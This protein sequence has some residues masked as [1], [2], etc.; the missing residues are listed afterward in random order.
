M[1]AVIFQT[2]GTPGGTMPASP[3]RT[4]GRVGRNL[5]ALSGE[6]LENAKRLTDAG[7]RI[8][9]M[10][11]VRSEKT[12]SAL[13]GLAREL[14]SS[15]AADAVIGLLSEC[16]DVGDREISLGDQSLVT[17]ITALGHERSMRL[18]RV[19][20]DRDVS[21]HEV[22]NGLPRKV[23]RGADPDELL[24]YAIRAV[25]MTLPN[26]KI[27]LS[28]INYAKARAAAGIAGIVAH[29]QVVS[30]ARARSSSGIPSATASPEDIP[31]PGEAVFG[32]VRVSFT[33]DPLVVTTV[34]RET[35]CCFSAGGVAA[36]LMRAAISS[37]VAGVIHGDR[38]C[39]WF[40]FV[41][42][43]VEEIDG[44][45]S[46][47]LIL[48]NL[49]ASRMIGPRDS[50]FLAEWAG[51]LVGT[52]RRVYLGTQRNDVGFPDQAGLVA[53]ER[54]RPAP[55]IP[56]H[57]KLFLGPYDDSRRVW[58]LA[59]LP[60]PP[61]GTARLSLA[62]PRD[63]TLSK[64]LEREVYGFVDDAGDRG[65]RTVAS[66]SFVLLD[67]PRLLGYLRTFVAKFRAGDDWADMG[68]AIRKREPSAEDDVS[69]L[70]VDDVVWSPHRAS[71]RAL[72]SAFDHLREWCRGKGVTRVSFNPNGFS[73]PLTKRV[74]DWMELRLTS[75]L[76]PFRSKRM[77]AD[78][79]WA[80]TGFERNF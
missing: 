39:R 3:V 49:E 24:D 20:R 8:Q 11:S 30:A 51:S 46:L 17:L 1:C 44:V 80:P 2:L 43:I 57:E 54:D 38:P 58:T 10:A 7:H 64:Y 61:P 6:E 75:G 79:R 62:T 12:V 35:G 41:W 21:V 63:L 32:G 76:E 5:V 65:M 16:R 71:R 34:G 66:P 31:I 28:M 27:A 25:S 33:K 53:T 69:V 45:P 68:K 59:D 9:S 73:R 29:S 15:G 78:P 60:P 74:P 55:G 48:D 19:V 14:G 50:G 26:M 67:G 77:P 52:Y 56:G 37:P 22:C 18:L 40:S 4:V 13:R 70:Y 47:C 42:E 72:L 36:G 23:R